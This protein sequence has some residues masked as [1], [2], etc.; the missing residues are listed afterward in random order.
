VNAATTCD[1]TQSFKINDET[2]NT[3]YI[4][5]ID[6]KREI[7]CVNPVNGFLEVMPHGTSATNNYSFEWFEGQNVTDPVRPETGPKI[8]GLEARQ[9][10]TVRVTNNDNGCRAVQTYDLDQQVNPIQMQAFASPLTE[11]VNATLGTGND[12]QLSSLVTNDVAGNQPNYRF[13]WFVD[14][15][16]DNNPAN[17][18]QIGATRI[19]NN[20]GIEGNQLIVGASTYPNEQ[21]YVI[22]F[23]TKDLKPNANILCRSE[24]FKVNIEDFRMPP[25]VVITEVMPMTNCVAT[26]ELAN[27]VASANVNGDITNY[28]FDWFK[29]T[30]A[31]P[32]TPPGFYNGVEASGLQPYEHPS[33][34]GVFV[35]YTVLATNLTSGCS[36]TAPLRIDNKPM[37]GPEVQVIVTSLN[38]RCDGVNTGELQANVGGVTANYVFD[39]YDGDFHDEVNAPRPTPD[40][41]GEFYSELANGFYSVMATSVITGCKSRLK[42]EEITPKTVIPDFEF[43]IVPALCEDSTGRAS[44]SLTVPDAEVETIVW[45]NLAGDVISTGPILG[46]AMTGDYV[47]TVTTLEACEKSK[48]VH[49]PSEIKPFNGISRNGDNKNSYFHINCIEEFESNIVKVFNRAGTLVYQ[50]E[51]YD[52]NNILFDG[53]SNKGI[54]PM[55]T[56]LPDGTYFYIIDKRNGSK[57]VAGY[58]EIV[59]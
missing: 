59:N 26:D 27:G 31:P 36:N 46:G 12:S 48:P 43:A 9:Y 1:V 3:V 49:I 40:N 56:N 15:G 23:D 10:F 20:V 44:I 35:E 54:S 50:A 57:P 39:W 8:T 32:V 21:I 51:G 47:V 58:L 41:V 34:P 33:R 55:G 19:I 4:E 29:G 7:R 42:A 2:I 45:K 28:T 52:N 37:A 16:N 25:P 5:L 17:D 11:C 53:I 38:V 24:L 6:F 22:A 14:I 13:D 18:V 30:P